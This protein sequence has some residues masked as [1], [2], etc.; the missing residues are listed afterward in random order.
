MTA[1]LTEAQAMERGR[2][3]VQEYVYR[4]CTQQW[5]SEHQTAPE[6]SQCRTIAAALMAVQREARSAALD[7]AAG[8]AKVYGETKPV[9]EKSTN[10]TMARVIAT[11][12][13]DTGKC[14]AAAILALKEPTP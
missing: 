9:L 4:G 13:S 12:M 5:L 10:G 6:A 2:Q 3:I 11:V 7:E 1:L 14:V 8:V